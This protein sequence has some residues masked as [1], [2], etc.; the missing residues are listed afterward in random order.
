MAPEYMDY[1]IKYDY[2][3]HTVYSHGKGGIEDNVRAAV[4]K[5]LSGIAI[6]DHGPGHLL[7]G[8]DR[9][10]IPE[11]RAEIERLREKYKDIDIYLSVEANMMDTGNCLDIGKD[12]IGG[13]DFIIAGYHY[14][15]RG[16]FCVRNFVH[17]HC[18]FVL[19]GHERLKHKNTDIA[20]KAIFENPI[21]IMTHPGDKGPFDITEIAKACAE[22]GTLLEINDGHEHLTL[23]GIKQA[24]ATEVG[25][26][27][28]SD[29]HTPDK[30]GSFEKGLKRALS[31]G[32]DPERIVNIGV[33]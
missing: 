12:E 8:V 26:I 17:A 18:P 9:E 22:R 31:V 5:G 33:C 28:C 19:P 6:T 16:G 13:Y 7:Y 25:F 24:A 29:A 21:K 4:H 15:V 3:T 23:E 2:H 27:I 20:V 14:G 11:M 32:L 10:K 30:V 1:F